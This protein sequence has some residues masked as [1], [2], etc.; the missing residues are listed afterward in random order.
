MVINRWPVTCT[1]T[2]GL[3]ATQ[4]VLTFP[5]REWYVSYVY[6][7]ECLVHQ[8]DAWCLMPDTSYITPAVMMPC[9]Q[10]TRQSP[11][12][13]AWHCARPRMRRCAMAGCCGAERVRWSRGGSEWRLV[14]KGTPSRCRGGG[15]TLLYTWYDYR[16]QLLRTYGT[17]VRVSEQFISLCI[18]LR[19]L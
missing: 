16:G 12:R 19:T 6:T 18:L 8:A 4:T 1:C 10:G 11:F 3:Y 5:D 7:P 2:A 13:H 17:Y 14:R 15:E 9:Q